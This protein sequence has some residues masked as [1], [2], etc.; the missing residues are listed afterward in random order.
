MHFPDLPAGIFGQGLHL[1]IRAHGY[2]PDV[3]VKRTEHFPVK[4]IA[5]D[6]GIGMAA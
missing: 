3:G 2:Y 1:H 6:H 5:G 4:F